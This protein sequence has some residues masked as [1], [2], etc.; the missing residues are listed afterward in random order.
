MSKAIDLRRAAREIFHAALSDMDAGDAVRR[1]VRLDGHRLAINGENVFALADP[2]QPIYVIAIGKAAHPMAAAVDQL[3][4]DRLTAGIIAGTQIGAADHQSLTRRVADKEHISNGGQT[5][6]SR[7]AIPAELSFSDRWRVFAG[8]HPL[9]NEAS[10]AAARASF[11]LLGRA[12]SERALVL[13]LISGGGSAMIEWPRDEQTTLAELSDANRVLVSCGAGIAEINAVR[14]AISAVK[15]GGLAACA[16]RAAQVSLIISDTNTGEESTVASGPTFAPPPDAPS[17]SSVIAC[18]KLAAHLPASILRAI[19]QSTPIE[20]STDALRKH[21]VLLD[22]ESA[23]NSAAAAARSRG[24]AVEIARDV[25]EQPVAEGCAE[26]L[27]R[28]LAL[29]RQAA[30]KGKV[31]CLISGGEF[32]CPVRGS[33]VGGRN[34]ETALRWAIEIDARRRQANDKSSSMH[35]VVLSAGTDGIDGNSPAAGALADETTIAR[36]RALN[37]DAQKFLETSDA[38]S[39]FNALGDTIVTGPTGTNVRDLRIM[40]A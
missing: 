1:A 29:R 16:P 34:A 18:Y 11:A 21:Y 13:F 25:V 31:I 8:G 37:L 26:L 6:N 22:N 14:R 19:N 12:N 39:F 20:A 33:G 36:A 28:L 17:A 32:A 5:H 38:Y 35:M 15:G 10:L 3:L 24:F 27:S 40:L 4:G 7:N 23:M 9:P 30:N 2:S